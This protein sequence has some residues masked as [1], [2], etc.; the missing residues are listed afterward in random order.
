MTR[1]QY[2][3]ITLA[4]AAAACSPPAPEATQPEASASAVPGDIAAVA[5]AAAPGVTITSGELN[6]GNTQYEVTGTLPNGDEIEIDLVQSNGAWTALEI[7]RDVAWSSVPEPVRAV[8]AAASLKARR[9]PTGRWSTNCFGRLRMEAPP[10]GQRWK[11]A[12]TKGVL[13]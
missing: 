3:F 1:I 13:K 6:P 8:A 12:G 2:A 9:S 11:C 7:Q 4:L 10:G 5:S